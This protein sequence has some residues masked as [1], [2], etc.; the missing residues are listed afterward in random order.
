MIR[1]HGNSSNR[2]NCIRIGVILDLILS[3][4]RH[5]A[6]SI[7]LTAL[8]LAA[9]L[10]GFIPFSVQAADLETVT[11][12]DH[13]IME[14]TPE[15]VNKTEISYPNAPLS[16]NETQFIANTSTTSPVIV[17]LP[18]TNIS[19]T[20]AVL[21]GYLQSLGN[22]SL[23]DVS[24]EWG[25]STT[26][27]SNTSASGKTI[28]GNYSIMISGLTSGQTYHYR[29]KADGGSYGISYGSDLTFTAIPPVPNDTSPIVSISNTS[30]TGSISGYVFQSDGMT[31]L[32]NASIYA[33]SIDS[34]YGKIGTSA[35]DGS[36]KIN[37]LTSGSYIVYA[38]APGY[39]TEYYKNVFNSGSA[40]PVPVTAPDNTPDINFTLDRGGT[41]SG[42][43]YKPDSITPVANADIFAWSSDIEYGQ[44]GTSDASGNYTIRDVPSGN[45]QVRVSASGY[46]TELYNNV[47]DYYAATLVKVTAPDNTPDINFIMAVGGTISGHVYKADGITPLAYAS[48]SANAVDS[49]FGGSGISN[50]DGSYIIAGLSSGNYRVQASSA[51]YIWQYYKNVYDANSATI[52]S[53]TAPNNT[54]DINFALSVGGAISGHIYKADGITPISNVY[55]FAE[56][57]GADID[58][59]GYGYSA[60][61]GSYAVT[62]LVSGSYRMRASASGYITEYYKDVYGYNQATTVSV[63]VPN[64]TSNID[65][66]LDLG[67]TISGYVY[68]SDGITPVVGAQISASESSTGYDGKVAS[69]IDGRYTITSLASGNYQVQA[70]AYGYLTEYYKNVSDSSRA[71]LVNVTAPDNTPGINFTLDK[72]G[73]ISGHIYNA[74]GTSP[75]PNVQIFAASDG[76][77]SGG[78]G[79]GISGADGSYVISGLYSG[80]YWVR[81]SISGYITKYYQDVYDQNSATLIDVI[82]PNSTSNINFTLYKGGTISGHVY[83]TDGITPVAGAQVYASSN[84]VGDSYY[85]HGTSGGDGSYVITGLI[86]GNYK[87]QASASGYLSEYYNNVYDSNSAASI[88]IVVLNNT[89]DINFTLDKG[90]S[91]SGHVYKSDGITPI[92]NASVSVFLVVSG[93]GTSVAGTGTGV[94]G[95]F[96]ITNLY[97]G[98]Y[99]VQASASGYLTK[100]YNNVYDSSAATSVSVTAPNT[101]SDI[102][103]LMDTGGSI[104]GYIFQSDGIVPIANASIYA[105]SVGGSYHSEG[106][107]TSVPDGSYTITGLYPGNYRVRSWASSFLAE[108]YKDVYDLNAFTS[109]SVNAPNKTSGINFTL[110]KGGTVSGHVYKADGITPVVNAS[111]VAYPIGNNLGYSSYGSSLS[112]ADGSYNVAGLYTGSYRISAQASGYITE[113]YRDS[114]DPDKATSVNVTAPDNTSGI[115]FT[116]DKGG[117][118]SGRV[119]LAD[120]ITPVRQRRN[121]DLFGWEYLWLL[122]LWRNCVRW[123][124][125]YH[126]FDFRK[127]HDAGLSLRL[128]RGVL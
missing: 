95:S 30:A 76:Y 97:S 42:R 7:C 62:G 101:T 124:L 68:Q 108:Y 117:T 21:N 52:V 10:A 31:G 102:N 77:G 8:L 19:N 27:A 16:T 119:C 1:A 47:Y 100:Y 35:A 105:E 113:Y 75:L 81:A 60:P 4:M 26:Y 41:I 89:P 86:S 45:Y 64:D 18:A 51:G 88:I 94:D 90:G 127:L 63:T 80:S 50:A 23:V 84:G 40:T 56:S 43:I 111:I 87:V 107:A 36:Y 120:G 72:G 70:S 38:C 9:I 128:F 37:G 66:T 14:F 104:S 17:T 3:T 115:D 85:G 24:F 67:G 103:F 57:T 61:D 59:W 54:P 106:N 22:S 114:Y 49:G 13:P 28:I 39:L 32:P 15:P 46:V 5:R 109:V 11:L 6:F 93:Q 122:W 25:T 110:D 121:P 83:K 125:C 118:I 78:V 79:S 33:W 65:F 99:K 55:I 96:T 34:S 92:A 44:S 73:T 48:I 71:T 126:R 29:A 82:A 98:S 58:Y 116:L 69:S 74:D 20:S 12:P 53:V 2:T 123:Q 112:G 91:I